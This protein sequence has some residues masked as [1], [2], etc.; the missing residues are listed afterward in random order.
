VRL[1]ETWLNP[2]LEE[3]TQEALAV[4][5]TTPMREQI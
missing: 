2:D 3:Y 5:D 1:D 4:L